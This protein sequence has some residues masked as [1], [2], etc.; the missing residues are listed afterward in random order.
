MPEQKKILVV[1][2]DPAMRDI[3]SLKL[4]NSGFT[5]FQ[6][7]DGKEALEVFDKNHPDLILLDLMLPEV[8]GF[9]VLETIR[10]MPDPALSQTPVIVLSNLWSDKDILRAKDLLVQEYLVKAYFTT[11]EIM[12]K[13]NQVFQKIGLV[14]SGITTGA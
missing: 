2:D 7:Q 6:A 12:N 3:V 8:D 11:E 10:K 13:I 4:Q 14:S 5:V 1:E 9:T